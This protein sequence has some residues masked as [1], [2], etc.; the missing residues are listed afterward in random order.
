MN[1]DLFDPFKY[2]PSGYYTKDEIAYPEHY[3]SGDNGIQFIDAVRAAL[4]KRGF[5]DFLRGQIM[6]YIWRMML[7]GAALKDAEK[8]KWY[9][10]KLISILREPGNDKRVV[11]PEAS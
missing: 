6:K 5:I 4:G 3:T 9:L 2:V 11:S 8:A 10:E 1:E 7:K